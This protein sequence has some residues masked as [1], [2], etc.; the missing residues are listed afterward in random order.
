MRKRQNQREKLTPLVK[1][2]AEVVYYL[3]YTHQL[4]QITSTQLQVG[5]TL[6]VGVMAPH[7]DAVCLTDAPLPME[8]HEY[9]HILIK[10]RARVSG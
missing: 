8:L 10:M 6:Y 7:R 1:I 5:R 2:G 9:R 4:K 3:I